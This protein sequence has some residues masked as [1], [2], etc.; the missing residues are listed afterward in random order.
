MAMLSSTAIFTDD[1]DGII[2]TG[3]TAVNRE[4]GTVRMLQA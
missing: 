2:M 4:L 1:N 3:L